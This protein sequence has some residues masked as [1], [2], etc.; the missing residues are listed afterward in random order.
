MLAEAAL[1]GWA[2]GRRVVAV[3]GQTGRAVDDVGLVTDDDGWVMVQAKKGLQVGEAEGSALAEAL[4]QLVEV[5]AEGV[6]DRPPWTERVRSLEAGRDLVLVLTDPSA[7]G[8]VDRYLVPVTDRLRDLPDAAPLSD[9]VTNEDEVRALR[10]LRE[11]LARYWPGSGGLTDP[12]FRYLT[13]FLSVRTMHLT[14]GGSD[15]VAAQ[16]LLGEL[17][18]DP[19]DA[20]RVW[21]ALEI[22]AQRLAEERSFLDR[23]GLIRRLEMREIRLR[24]LARLRPDIQRLRDRTRLNMQVPGVALTIAAPERAV[25]LSRE[26]G[27]AIA[28]ADGN[29]AITG[30]PGTGMAP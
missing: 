27:P 5:H 1:P 21:E 14:D 17:T 2:S 23:D 11:H 30:A 20:R 24:P 15:Q 10:V 19:G 9:V 4:R 13:R 22:E 8:T 29:L 25:G 6:P 12:D 18:D 16:L 26:I 3:G 28:E 7:A